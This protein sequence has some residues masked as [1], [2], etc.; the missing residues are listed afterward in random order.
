MPWFHATN[1]TWTEADSAP[2]GGTAIQ[3]RA[4][5]TDISPEVRVLRD[6]ETIF[7]LSGVDPRPE[8]DTTHTIARIDPASAMGAPLF[9]VHADA[10]DLIFEDLRFDGETLASDEALEYVQSA[11]NEILIPVY[12]DDVVSDLSERVSGIVILHTVQ[13]KSETRGEWSY[14]R[15]SVFQNG[16][17]ALEHEHGSL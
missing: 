14:F 7:H 9:A 11:L 15:T 6:G 8:T 5:D 4:S 13:Y 2:N 10:N 12:I 17:L 16:A 1:G 3:V